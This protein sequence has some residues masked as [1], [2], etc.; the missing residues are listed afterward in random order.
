MIVHSAWL[1]AIWSSKSPS[2][3][4]KIHCGGPTSTLSSSSGLAWRIPSEVNYNPPG[5]LH[6]SFYNTFNYSSCYSNHWDLLYQSSLVLDMLQGG[7]S[8]DWSLLLGGLHRRAGEVLLLLLL[9]LRLPTD[10]LLTSWDPDL[11]RWL[12]GDGVWVIFMLYGST[13]FPKLFE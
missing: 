12:W 11:F 10:Y 7:T 5:G 3:S 13:K 9:D 4:T 2:W 1:L 6:Y 8:Q